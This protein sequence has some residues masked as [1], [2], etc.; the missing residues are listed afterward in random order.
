MTQAEQDLRKTLMERAR[1]ADMRAVAVLTNLYDVKVWTQE[2]I[3]ALNK[4]TR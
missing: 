1:F 2:Q 4:E 3:N